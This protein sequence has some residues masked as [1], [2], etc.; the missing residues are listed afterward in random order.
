MR[1]IALLALAFLAGCSQAFRQSA[2]PA[3]AAEKRVEF[4]GI[5]LVVHLAPSASHDSPLIIYVTGDT[6]WWD[7]DEAIF[8]TLSTWGYPVAGVSAPE[9]LDHLDHS[10]TSPRPDDIAADFTAI[11]RTAENAFELP[12]S[13]A[14]VFV[15]LSRGAGLAVAAAY[16]SRFEGRLLGILAIALTRE[17]ENALVPPPGGDSSSPSAPLATYEVL[18]SLGDT[19]VAIIQS[20]RDEYVTAS[21]ARNLLG[22]DTESRRLRAIDA[23]DHSFHGGIRTLNAELKHSFEW[24]VQ[25]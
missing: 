14:L 23:E 7:R 11:V 9:Y 8:H 24:I 1:V 17:E 3:P 25:R 18:S 2:G 6:G 16:A 5:D 20:T 21:E 15:G 19:R 12:P 4:H 22:P 10:E 13:T